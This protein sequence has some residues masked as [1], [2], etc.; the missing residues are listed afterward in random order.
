MNNLET[1]LYEF[2]S[3]FHKG[4]ALKRIAHDCA[5]IA[6]KEFKKNEKDMAGNKKSH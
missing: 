4:I 5:Q 2:L 1:K 6:E 3:N